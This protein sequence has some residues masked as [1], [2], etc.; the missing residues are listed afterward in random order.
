MP[1]IYTLLCA[2]ML[3]RTWVFKAIA[4]WISGEVEYAR[5]YFG[6]RGHALAARG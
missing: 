4:Q 1:T 3:Q 6:K 5:T 2:N